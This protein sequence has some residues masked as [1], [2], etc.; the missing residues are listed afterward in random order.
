MLD[1]KPAADKRGS[2]SERTSN[3]QCFASKDGVLA[4]SPASEIEKDSRSVAFVWS[5]WCEWVGMDRYALELNVDIGPVLLA[6]NGDLF[7]RV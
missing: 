7:Q 3:T 1:I 2:T 4:V 6:T 5:L